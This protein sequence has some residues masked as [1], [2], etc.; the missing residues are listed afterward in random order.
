MKP[1]WLASVVA[2]TL[3]ACGGDSSGPDGPSVATVTVTAPTTTMSIDETLQLSADV[4]DA[5]GQVV[6]GQT[7]T[8]ESSATGVATVN[9]SGLVT[10]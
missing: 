8:W 2:M 6:V 7:I 4:R 1:R 5:Q 9:G 10:G 3:A